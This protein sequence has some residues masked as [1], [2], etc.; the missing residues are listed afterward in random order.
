M[1]TFTGIVAGVA[2]LIA[3][4]LVYC[5]FGYRRRKNDE[6]WHVNSEELNFSHPVEVIGQGAF[7]VVIAAEYRGTRVAIKRVL[8]QEDVTRSRASSVPSGSAMLN[9]NNSQELVKSGGDLEQGEESPDTPPTGEGRESAATNDS[10][11]DDVLG[12]LPIARKKSR[13]QKWLP[14]FFHDEFTRSKLMVLGSATG[15]SGTTT[16]SLFARMCLRCDETHR[17]QEEFKEEMRL[18]SRLRH[19]CKCDI[20]CRFLFSVM[21]SISAF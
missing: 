16:R 5:Y 1:G 6:V 3:F 20:S 13:L 10:N 8:P 15:G 17:R 21:C 19:P 7:G 11:L 2:S 4:Q 9:S 18:L 14:S 12:G